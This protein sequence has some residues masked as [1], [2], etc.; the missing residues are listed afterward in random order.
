ME[1]SSRPAAASSGATRSGRRTPRR[2]R[3]G[4]SAC[5]RRVQAAGEPRPLDGAHEDRVVGWG[6]DLLVTCFVEFAV[7]AGVDPLQHPATRGV[8]RVPAAHLVSLPAGSPDEGWWGPA[9][10]AARAMPISAA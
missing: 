5:L 4:R 1:K 6:P 9:A 8:A 3:R 10:D 2:A 7:E